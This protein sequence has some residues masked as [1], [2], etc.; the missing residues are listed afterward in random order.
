M[1]LGIV[2]SGLIAGGRME[3]GET[4]CEWSMRPSLLLD[5]D[6]RAKLQATPA[7]EQTFTAYAGRPVVRA[8][9]I[10]VSLIETGP[11]A[12]MLLGVGLALRR[13][14]GGSRD[15]LARALT[16]LRIASQAA[17]AWAIARPLSDSLMDSLLSAGTPDGARWQISIDLL[18]IGTALML[19][20]AAFATVWALEAGLRAQR[21]LDDFV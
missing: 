12:L 10:G 2:L 20:T 11:F 8:G 18:D 1:A 21:D 19:G 7:A 6:D 5:D 4:G 17:L 14:G 9:I 13:L 15:A 16:W 3:C